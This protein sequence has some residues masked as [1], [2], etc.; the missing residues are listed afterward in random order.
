MS[1]LLHRIARLWRI[2]PDPGLRRRRLVPLFLLLLGLAPGATL[3]SPDAAGAHRLAQTP[4]DGRR[5]Y[6]PLL[7]SSGA[8]AADG[9]YRYTFT[10]P[11]ISVVQ[12]RNTYRADGAPTVRVV[13][14]ARLDGRQQWEPEEDWTDLP[15]RLY[16][17]DL[18]A[19]RVVELI[20]TLRPLGPPDANPPAA[21]TLNRSNVG[22]A[23]WSGEVTY[24]YLN[25]DIA[26][27]TAEN[28]RTTVTFRPAAWPEAL[29]EALRDGLFMRP[30]PTAMQARFSGFSYDE[31]DPPRKCTYDSRFTFPIVVAE[32]YLT[33]A[34]DET[35]RYGGE[36]WIPAQEALVIQDSCGSNTLDVGLR[37]WWTAAVTV[38]EVEQLQIASDGRTISGSY[39]DGAGGVYRWTLRALPPE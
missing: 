23:G 2:L 1:R 4:P 19:E 14:R 38:E 12:F 34:I 3:L 27:D 9:S 35:R 29:P 26:G 33:L 13:A 7:R 25:E 20:I 31:S 17:R 18:R 21:P 37:K 30:E 28:H 15:E 11:T 5:I 22:C 10:D 24:S 8:S 16:C 36:G 6:L 39:T 32:S